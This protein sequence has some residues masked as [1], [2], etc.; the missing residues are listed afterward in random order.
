[1]RLPSASEWAHRPDASTPDP[2]ADPHRTS[3]RFHDLRHTADTLAAR[4]CATTKELMT[5]L[6]HASA[7]TALIYQHDSAER[8][9][10]IA[11]GLTVMNRDAQSGSPSAAKTG[12][13]RGEKA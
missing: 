11:D 5:R 2:D 3:R 4:T 9:K 12:G 8:D 10:S 1:M 13:P 7:N 6:G